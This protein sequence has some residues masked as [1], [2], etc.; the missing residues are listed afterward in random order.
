MEGGTLPRTGGS[1]TPFA[2]I[3]AAK[4]CPCLTKVGAVWPFNWAATDPLNILMFKFVEPPAVEMPIC[5]EV[6][7]IPA[8]PTGD[9]ILKLDFLSNFLT[10]K[11]MSPNSRSKTVWE[12]LGSP[13]ISDSFLPLESNFS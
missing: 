1:I 6:P 4:L 3:P 2:L 12:E 5:P 7:R 10:S 11:T 8:V 13:F 9:S